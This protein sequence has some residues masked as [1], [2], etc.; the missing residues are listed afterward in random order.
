M[1]HCI[2]LGL[3]VL[4]GCGTKKNPALVCTNGECSDPHYPYCDVDGVLGGEPNTC[5]AVSC[6][7]GDFGACDGD[8][9]VTCDANGTGYDVKHCLNGCST[10][11]AGCNPC[12]PNM[13]VCGADGVLDV[14]DSTGHDTATQCA[15]GC[16]DSP[17][18]HCAYLQPKYLPN[19]ICDVAAQTQLN[20]TDNRTI[21][22]SVDANCNGGIL[23]QS[24]GP[25]L[26]VIRATSMTVASAATLRVITA[27]GLGPGDV[28]SRPAVF[29]VDGDL[30][31]EGTLDAGASHEDSGPGGGFS[32][33]GGNANS[34]G[35]A[36]GGAG[37][38]TPGGNGGTYDADGGA[39]NGGPQLS[40]PLMTAVFVGGPGTYGAGGGGGVM[41]TSCRG[42]V[43]VA[44]TINVGGGGGMSGYFV[45]C[46]PGFGG[47]GGGNVLIEAMNVSITGAL[48]ANGGGGGA[49]CVPNTQETE[50]HGEDGSMSD[51]TPANGGHARAGAGNGGQ[52]GIGT[53]LPGDGRRGQMSVGHPGGGGGSVGWLQ[54]LTPAGVTPTLTPSHVSPPL[55]PNATAEVR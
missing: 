34:D 41:L 20:I 2:A 21:D 42:T 5:I 13:K 36:A 1:W 9:V 55:Q 7:P 35:T 50:E 30:S 40:N 24:G 46:F 26:C 3:L 51:T 16:V 52:G 33:S 23:A 10:D 38:A 18:P 22:T 32:L 15:A 11:A 8:N 47:G 43:S 48:F 49:G 28:R 44:G 39:Q 54:T 4:I 19:D 45:A 12:E 14:C 17:E 25:D 29:V 31:V 37:F 27:S 53:S 6:T